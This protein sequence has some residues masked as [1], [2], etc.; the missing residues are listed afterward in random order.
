MLTEKQ[1]INF[2]RKVRKLP[3]SKCWLWKGHKDK[4]GFG[5]FYINQKPMKVHRL[6]YILHIG[7]I[8]RGAVV[9]HIPTCKHKNCCNP[10][11]LKLGKWGINEK[12]PLSPLQKIEKYTE[13]TEFCWNWKGAISSKFPVMRVGNKIVKVHRFL[14][15][16]KHGPLH[17][18]QRV[19]HECENLSCVNPEHLYIGEKKTEKRLPKE[20]TEKEKEKFSSEEAASEILEIRKLLLEGVSQTKLA[21]QFNRSIRE[22]HF[23]CEDLL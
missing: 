9:L 16:Q 12:T 15:E 2:W 14:Y 11:H 22:I 13:K 17:N 6:S 18:R 5:V 3:I 21:Q 10:K 1:V 8:P 20:L 4:D 19:L 7:E 23:I